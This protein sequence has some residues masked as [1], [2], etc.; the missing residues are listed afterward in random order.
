[1]PPEPVIVTVAV[2]PL[3]RI[4]EVTDAVPVSAAGCVTSRVPVNG[5]QLLA[6]VILQEYDVPAGIPGKTPVEFVTPLKVYDNGA[7]PPVPVSVTVAVPPL[8][9]IAVVT[10]AD[11]LIATGSV[12]SIDPVAGVQLLASVM[13]HR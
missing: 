3:H 8:H 5:P 10:D 2:P 13:L 6:S 4:A 11:P 1:M 12:T 9:V 7:V